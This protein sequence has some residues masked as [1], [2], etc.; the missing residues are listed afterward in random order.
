MMLL[1]LLLLLLPLATYAN[2][3]YPQDV[4]GVPQEFICAYRS[5]AQRYAARLRP[6]AALEAFAALQL[7]TL[8]N[9]TRPP[10]PPPLPPPALPTFASTLYVDAAR[11]DDGAAGTIAAP[12]KTLGAGVAKS[13]GA[14]R[15]A[16]VLLRAGTYYLAATVALTS[17]DSGL[18]IASFPGELAWLSGAPGA[19]PPLAWSPF[20]V[21]NESVAVHPGVNNAHG[22]TLNATTSACAC[23][24]TGTAGACEAALLSAGVNASSFTWH[25]GAQKAWALQCCLRIDGVWAPVCVCTTP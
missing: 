18:T 21:H 12:L 22:C 1:L 17:S 16:A 24:V 15:P 7:D 6:D 3:G 4:P 10:P 20:A 23:S 9:A 5:S 2:T 13:R 11:G 19:L 14:S 25:D 8:C